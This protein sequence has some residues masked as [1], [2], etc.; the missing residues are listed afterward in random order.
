MR[1]L[2]TCPFGLSSMVWQ[3]M[4]LLGLR[5]F[6]SFATGTHVEATWPQVRMLNMRS[7]IANKISVSLGVAQCSS[8]EDMFQ[9]AQQVN[10]EEYFIAGQGVEVEVFV[11]DKEG[12]SGMRSVQS[13]VHKAIMQHLAGD[14][15]HREVLEHIEP[16]HV[17][18]HITGQNVELFVNTSGAPLHQRGWRK[19]TWEAPLKENLA[20]A[21]VLMSSRKYRELLRDPCCGSGTIPIEAAM[22]ARNIAP[23][24]QRGFVFQQFRSFDKGQ[25]NDLRDQAIAKQYKDTTYKIMGSDIDETVL[26]Y[27]RQHAEHAGVADTIT[28]KLHDVMEGEIFPET[29]AQVKDMELWKFKW[30]IVSNPPYDKRLALT[31]KWAFYRSFSTFFKDDRKGAI[32][33]PFEEETD[34]I[35]WKLSK[36]EVKNGGLTCRVYRAV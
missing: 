19:N 33:L 10:R 30:Y 6:D 12:F 11:H 34:R 4:Q 29:L 15:E 13:I 21:L 35:L 36:K 23:W 31:D 22:I 3:E 18:V 20:A 14:D 9:L 32:L 26:G 8:F 28:W 2:I 7:R 16:L 1:C 24:L 27:A 17:S 25:R 5:S